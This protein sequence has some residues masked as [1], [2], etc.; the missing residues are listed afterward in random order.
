MTRPMVTVGIAFLAATFVASFF[1]GIFIAICFGVILFALIGLWLLRNSARR[2]VYLVIVVACL[3]G[4][5]NYWV[6]DRF[7]HQPILKLN[8]QTA[9]ITAVVTGQYQNANGTDVYEVTVKEVEGYSLPNFKAKLYSYLPIIIEEY[10]TIQVPVEFHTITNST[11]FDAQTVNQ[12]KELYV[13]GYIKGEPTMR[14]SP[15]IR[16]LRYYLQQLNDMLCEKID[17][18]LPQPTSSIVKAML[19]GNQNDMDEMAERVLMRAGVIHIVS[20]SGMHISFLAGFLFFLFKLCQIPKWISS[21]GCIVIIWLFVALVNFQVATVRS[22]IM[23]T[24]LLAGNLFGR[25]SEHVNSLFLSGVLIVWNNP[26]AIFSISFQLTF[27][28]T[29]G[30]LLC[31]KPA[32]NWVQSKWGITNRFALSLIESFACTIGATLFTLPI[33]VHTFS[34]IS[35][36]SPIANLIAAVITPILMISGIALL[37]TA[38]IPLLTPISYVIAGWIDVLNTAFLQSE[39][40]LQK[41]NN[42]F[43]G[44]NYRLAKLWITVSAIG[45]FAV[46]IVYWI[47]RLY[48]SGRMILQCV[49][50]SILA[51]AG[52][53]LY[54]ILQEQKD[55]KITTIGSYESQAVVMTYQNKATVI[56][57]KT[58]GYILKSVVSFLDSKN[59]EQIETL[60]LLEQNT[61]KIQDFS[62]LYNTK[63]IN[64]IMLQP[65]NSL[66]DFIKRYPNQNSKLLVLDKN[67]RVQVG[68]CIGYELNIKGARGSFYLE[69][70]NVKIGITNDEHFARSK[71]F[72]TLYFSQKKFAGIEQF[73]VKYVILIDRLEKSFH[74]NSKQVF[75][76]FENQIELTVTQ[77]GVYR[78]RK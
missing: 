35:L 60:I 49:S 7:E 34:G 77:N 1:H 2:G 58:D 26:F 15:K 46:M 69:A 33:M 29:L 3:A 6:K 32:R 19:L 27:F 43:L 21:A 36:I 14:N 74:L 75:D 22:A 37:L 44:T 78:I 72:D 11:V 12:A 42:A 5:V 24:V 47:K 57:Y 50:F 41:G 73:S 64:T 63:S 71:I 28:A 18:L 66:I 16:P 13:I 62:F 55:F 65:D 30:V 25:P 68:K 53:L 52:V 51:F 54:G 76:A 59:I 23:V 8:N 70:G 20:I 61:K 45:I 39:S 31:V 56:T 67:Y 48:L 9:I 4:V 10:D 40:F 38:S 17:R